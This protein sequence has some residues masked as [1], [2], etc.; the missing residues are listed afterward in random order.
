MYNKRINIVAKDRNCG[1]YDKYSVNETWFAQY[2]R[3]I[4]S[5]IWGAIDF[6]GKE[7]DEDIKS[8]LKKAYGECVIDRI[9][10]LNDTGIYIEKEFH[11]NSKECTALQ[12][13]LVRKKYTDL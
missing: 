8:V 2:G 6:L 9:E 10:E 7:I 11:H 1:E 5:A 13:Q 4:M 3:K 12:R